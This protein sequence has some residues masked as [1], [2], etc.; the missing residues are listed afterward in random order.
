MKNLVVLFLG[1][2]FSLASAHSNWRAEAA[3]NRTDAIES[4]ASISS[5]CSDVSIVEHDQFVARVSACG[6]PFV[7][8]FI[9]DPNAYYVDRDMNLAGHWVCHEVV[10]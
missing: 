7:C 3:K 4:A 8:N 10:R 1:V 6:R 9:D 2:F 5:A